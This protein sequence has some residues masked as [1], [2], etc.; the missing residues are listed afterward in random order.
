MDGEIVKSCLESAKK[1][2]LFKLCVK[3]K[4]EEKFSPEQLKKIHFVIQT[5]K[6]KALW[7]FAILKKLKALKDSGELAALNDTLNG[8]LNGEVL[9][10]CLVE[11]MRLPKFLKCAEAGA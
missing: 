4:A 9:K 1:L 2:P 8:T 10:T 5:I 7:K 6:A 3:K 11:E